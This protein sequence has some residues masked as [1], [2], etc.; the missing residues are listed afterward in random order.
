MLQLYRRHQRPCR[1]ASRRYRNCNCAIWVQGSLRGEYI[2]RS[3]DLRSWAAATD[4]VRDWEA[5]GEIGVAK[6]P[7]TPTIA[8]AITLF[9]EDL[10][11]QQ[12]V[13]ETIRK[14]ENLLERRLQLWC[15]ATGL[16]HLRQ[17]GVDEVRQFRSTWA[18]GPGYAAK[19]LE[20]LRAFFRFCIQD[21]WISKNPARAVKAPRLA[22][23][24][25][26]PF[27]PQE[28]ERILGACHSYPGNRE[29]LRAFVLVMRYSGLRIGDVIALEANRLCDGKLLLYTA[30]TGTPV[31]VPLPNHVVVALQGLE[32]TD[33]GRYFSSGRAK[34]QTARANWSRYLDALFASAHVQEGHSHRFRDTFA[35]ELLTAGVPLESVSVLLGHSSIKVTE[36]HYRPW[37]RSLQRKLEEQVSSAWEMESSNREG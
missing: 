32:L 14:Y 33:S 27:T 35:V 13:R 3:L 8:Q 29:R 37:V 30:K 31:Y 34:P 23:A 16:R 2:R 7:D 1:F 28:I 24:P 19:N 11:A 17:L 5:A 21:D 6:K 36:K 25:T 9:I 4:L 15:E 18:D 20:R 10:R 12:L 26:L 22:I